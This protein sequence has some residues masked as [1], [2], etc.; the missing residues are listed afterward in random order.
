MIGT[1]SGAK[2]HNSRMKPKGRE[3][4]PRPTPSKTAKRLK[5]EGKNRAPNRSTLLKPTGINTTGGHHKI[6]GSAK[7]ENVHNDA[8]GKKRMQETGFGNHSVWGVAKCVK[9]SRGDRDKKEEGGLV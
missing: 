4:K 2:T 8:W 1:K 6:V 5:G 3:K 7:E 9:I